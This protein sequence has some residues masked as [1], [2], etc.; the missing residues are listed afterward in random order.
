MGKGLRKVCKTD[1][2]DISQDLSPLVESGSKV[3]HFIPEPR[4][5]AEVTKLSVDIQ[6]PWLKATQKKTK[7]LINNDNFLAE[8]PNKGEPVTPCMDDYWKKN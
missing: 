3:S 6:K 7:N 4:R 8:D 5:F 2:K 1:V